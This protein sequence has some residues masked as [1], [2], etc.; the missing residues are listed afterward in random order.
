[1]VPYER[2]RAEAFWFHHYERVRA[3]A[4]W[5]YERVRAEASVLYRE[6]S[7]VRGGF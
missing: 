4:F 2:V 7:K 1:L 6:G 3:E 5:F